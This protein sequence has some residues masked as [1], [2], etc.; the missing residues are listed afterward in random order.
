MDNW[1]RFLWRFRFLL[2]G[3]VLLHSWQLFMILFML[4]QRK[5]SVSFHMLPPHT[6]SPPALCFLRFLTAGILC[7]LLWLLSDTFPIT[8]APHKNMTFCHESWSDGWG[9]ELPQWSF[10]HTQCRDVWSSLFQYLLPTGERYDEN[11]FLP[12]LLLLI[13]KYANIAIFW[14]GQLYSCKVRQLDPFSVDEL[15]FAH[16]HPLLTQRR[17]KIE[18]LWG[19]QEFLRPEQAPLS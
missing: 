5:S 8:S 10:C 9:E 2:D 18:S 3:K 16:R 7:L 6:S 4:E 17:P 13:S 15:I 12:K 19:K 1:T 11:Q 14:W